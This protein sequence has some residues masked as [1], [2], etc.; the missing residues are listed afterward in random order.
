[1]STAASSQAL[2]YQREITAEPL[3]DSELKLLH[4]LLGDP[5]LLPRDFK[6]WVTDHTADTIDISKSQV[7]GLIN[8][9]GTLIFSSASWEQ[10]GAALCPMIVPYP[11]TVPPKNWL[12]CDGSFYLESVYPQLFSYLGHAHDPFG[13]TGNFAVPDLRGRT[14]YGYDPTAG[15]GT[16]PFAAHDSSAVGARGGGH[17]HMTPAHSHAMSHQHGLSYGTVQAGSNGTVVTGGGNDTLTGGPNVAGTSPAGPDP[18]SGPPPLDGG[19]WY[20]L[21]YIIA[22]GLVPH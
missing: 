3:T 15:T 12:S 8:S 17:H 2:D 9:S 13:N 14:I 1:M 22:S 4:R 16:M 19:A 10:L 6:Q 11:A 21:N 7:H 5:S 18:T 20:A